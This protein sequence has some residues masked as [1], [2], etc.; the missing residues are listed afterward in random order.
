MR[1][2]GGAGCLRTVAGCTLGG[3]WGVLAALLISMIHAPEANPNDPLEFEGYTPFIILVFM[4]AG[5]IF[6]VIVGFLVANRS[7]LDGGRASS[8]G[9]GRLAPGVGLREAHLRRAM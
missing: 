3:V 9:I 6:G 4:P 2:H 7:D 5:L 1:S 8:L